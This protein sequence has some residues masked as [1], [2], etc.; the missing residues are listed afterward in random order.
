MVNHMIIFECLCRDCSWDSYDFMMFIEV[1]RNVHEILMG[2]Y[3]I[4]WDI[5]SSIRGFHEPENEISLNLWG[6]E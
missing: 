2:F 3:G 5:T 4:S 1:S 6:Y